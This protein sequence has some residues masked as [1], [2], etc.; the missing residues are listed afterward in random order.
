MAPQTSQ[1]GE[2]LMKLLLLWFWMRIWSGMS[3]NVSSADW[4]RAGHLTTARHD[5]SS[6]PG[7]RAEQQRIRD[8]EPG[9]HRDTK[10]QSKA[11]QSEGRQGNGH[12]WRWATC[13]AG[14]ANR[15]S[16]GGW[17]DGTGVAKATRAGRLHSTAHHAQQAQHSAGG[18]SQRSADSRIQILAAPLPRIPPV[19]GRPSRAPRLLD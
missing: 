11:E 9:A 13:A 2:T 6:K 1:A 17:G 15:A 10:M 7:R 5:S 12:W 19:I 8:K 16:A 3:G 14:V 18:S 4:R